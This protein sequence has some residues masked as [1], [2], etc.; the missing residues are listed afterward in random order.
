M[1]TGEE[2]SCHILCQKSFSS[3]LVEP[4]DISKA[5]VKEDLA[6]GLFKKA[7]AKTRVLNGGLPVSVLNNQHIHY[8]AF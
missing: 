3:A 5:S 6:T 7:L 1:W 8:N 2:L 4:T